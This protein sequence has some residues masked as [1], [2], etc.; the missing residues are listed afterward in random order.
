MK[1]E[2][3]PHVPA[4]EI[5]ALLLYIIKVLVCILCIH[6]LEKHIHPKST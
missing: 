2:I 5:I 3:N 4:N 6:S 1:K